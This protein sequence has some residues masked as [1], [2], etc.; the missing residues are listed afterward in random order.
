MSEKYDIHQDFRLLKGMS[1]TKISPMAVK[2]LNFLNRIGCRLF[3][4][5]QGI[6]AFG[7]SIKSYDNE[8]V[9]ITLFQPEHPEG[10]LP[11]LLYF[12]GGGFMFGESPSHFRK[13]C[14]YAAGVPCKVVFVQYRLALKYPFPKGIEDCYSSLLWT[15]ENAELLGIDKTRI[16]VGGDSAGGCLAA[17]TALMARDRKGPNICF[18]MLIYPVLDMEQ[19]SESIQRF[20]DTPLWNSQLN[21]QMWRIYLRNGD[22]SM[23]E[24]A[25]P[26][27]AD[28]F[29]NLP[30]AYIET[31][32]FDCL[33]DEGKSYA[34]RLRENGV[35]VRLEETKGTIHAYDEIKRSLI[36]KTA[37]TKRIEALKNI[38]GI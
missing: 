22:F 18:Q 17:G 29:Y 27:K 35:K 5:P 6:K 16:A 23:I 28:S 24:Y 10:K 8:S 32:E 37:M 3:R 14:E 12:H 33:R 38:F 30:D 7:Y 21:S 9:K 13:V 11:C 25:S 1:F 4:F 34:Q 2:S 26:L 15:Y 36:T 31:A 20:T 19:D